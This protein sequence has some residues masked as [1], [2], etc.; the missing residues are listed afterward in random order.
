M[1]SLTFIIKS[2]KT[3][4]KLILSLIFLFGIKGVVAQQFYVSKTGNDAFVGSIEKPFATISRAQ[5]EVKIYKKKY[6]NKKINVYIR[7]GKYQLSSSI[8]FG[9][10][11]GGNPNAP[12]IYQAYQNEKPILNC[13]IT[14]DAK[15]WTP[16]SKEAKERVH[17]K[18]NANKLVALDLA[19]LEIRNVGQFAPKNMFTTEWYTI[20]VF[21]NNKR[22]PI[23]KWPN[24]NENI[25]GV[26]D[27]GWTTTNGSKN[28]RS[29]YFAEG[30]K[31]QDNDGYNEI[32]AD[33]SNRSQRWANS[34]KKGH[35]L[36]LKGVWRT[37]WDPVTAKVEEINLTDKSITLFNAPQLGMGSKYSPNVSQN[38]EYRAGSG[39]EGFYLINY[40]D[41][42]DEPGEWAVDFKDKK[43]YYYPILPIK[44]LEITIADNKDPV[45]SLLN[46]SNLQFIGLTIEGSLGNG[47][48]LKNTQNIY[49]ANCEVKNIGNTAIM[50]DG[51]NHHKIQSNNIFDV[52]ACGIDIKNVGSR[53]QLKSSFDTIQNNYIH[54]IGV[55]NFREAIFIKNAV[56]V[57]LSNNLIHDVPKGAFRSDDINNCI[58]EYNEIHNIA[59]KEGDTGVFYNYGGW[60]TYGNIFRYNFS[61]HTNRAN[62][63]YSDDGDSGDFYYKNIVQ[64]V[65]S[66]VKFGG[67]HHNIAENNLIV[68]SKDQT[69]DDRG[70]AR[71][72]F[73]G[74]KYE[75]NLTKFNVFA[76]PWLTYGKQLKEKYNL[77]DSLWSDILKANWQP[78]HPNGSRMINNVAVKSGPFQKSK[79]GKVE[80]ANNVEIATIQTADFYNYSAMDLRSKNPILLAKYPDLNDMFLKMGLQTDKFRKVIPT[81]KETGGL[82]NRTSAETVDAED[83][84]IDKVNVKPK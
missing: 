70:I 22:Q 28:E 49:I 20:D 50:I 48:D 34:L 80:I 45:I 63:F 68:E 61:H 76:E 75:T 78:E 64:G 35:E 30:G 33:G 21:A 72:Y 36:W 25:R 52:A 73:L 27:P 10:E 38:P 84:M 19:D 74:T 51:G 81:R 47:F 3:I 26:N 5:Q 46:T 13:A 9:Q 66:A 56:G 40:L 59:L 11:D 60:S 18:V 6:P 67:G 2:N 43:L 42:I 65:V 53:S 16:L 7:G 29:F 4:T 14:I 71:N 57:V 62:G 83:K 12:V 1:M 8:K 24:N 39:K 41:E 82:S 32:D 58:F 77:K 15:S 69:I 23:S 17:P 37:P 44:E 55:L 31:P 79:N 54:H